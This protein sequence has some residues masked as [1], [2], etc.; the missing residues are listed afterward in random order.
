MIKIIKIFDLK[1]NGSEKRKTFSSIKKILKKTDYIKGESVF[2]FENF[3]KNIIGAKYCVSCN[4]GSDAL[5]LI[6]KS[7]SLKKTDEVITT[8]HSWISTSEAIVNAGAKPVFVDTGHDFNID[9]D[10]IENEI[11][12]NTKA[13]LIVHLFGMPCNISK[14]L[15]LSK[16]YN[17]KVI[18]D[19]AQSH[20][21]KYKD[22][23]VGN[24]GYASAFSFFPTKNLGAAGDAGCIIT[25]NK[26]LA[27]KIR[28]L[29]N[30][31]CDSKNK[32]LIYF[33]G[34]NSRLDTLQAAFLIQ[35]LKSYKKILLK[36]RF[37]SNLYFE[38]LKNIK[39]IELP[40][41]KKDFQPNFYLFT[42]KAKKRDILRKYLKLKGIETGI[43]YPYILPKQKVYSKIVK[44]KNKF[45]Q[46]YKNSRSMISLPI[47]SNLKKKD[48]VYCSRI[49]KKFYEKQN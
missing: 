38:L 11:N 35:R 19:C 6:L 9:P 20:F 24:F 2:K 4:S 33:D 25:N 43:Y 47:H 10:K 16:R 3:F 31:G 40:I 48:I 28:S 12:R 34:I 22:K 42:I 26:I 7:L 21:S 46:S 32:N 17:L 29:A 39:Q 45:T 36:K 41:K 5:F 13:I 30:H 8:S 1:L 23:Y 27:K 37:I 49:I 15:K 44:F 18:E 14:I